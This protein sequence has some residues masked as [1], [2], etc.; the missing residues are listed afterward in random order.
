M[1]VFLVVS[2]TKIVKVRYKKTDLS[3]IFADTLSGFH[4]Y[5]LYEMPWRSVFR[6]MV[7]F[8]RFVLEF[9]IKV[10][11]SNRPKLYFCINTS[12]NVKNS[13]N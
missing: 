2:K 1:I 13:I 6:R 3:A 9:E 12:E 5:M 7:L 8:C 4:I 11:N 10:S